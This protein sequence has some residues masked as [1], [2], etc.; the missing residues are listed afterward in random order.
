[1]ASTAQN[2]AEGPGQARG[3]NGQRNTPGSAGNGGATGPPAAGDA[4]GSRR[5]LG[6]IS[7]RG[8]SR[9][10]ALDAT[11]L[12]SQAGDGNGGGQLGGDSLP[13]GRDAGDP[14]GSGLGSLTGTPGGTSS[15]QRRATGDVGG[16]ADSQAVANP[17]QGTLRRSNLTGAI[18][19]GVIDGGA[20]TVADAGPGDGS[21]A[22]GGTGTGGTY[23]PGASNGR[24]PM[25]MSSAAGSGRRSGAD[26][27]RLPAGGEGTGG[28]GAGGVGGGGNA[29]GLGARLS[30]P[31]GVGTAGGRRPGGE[32]VAR[33]GSGRMPGRRVDQAPVID[34]RAREPAR[35][36]AGRGGQR[37]AHEGGADGASAR[38]EAAVEAGLHFLAG[39]Q[40]PAGSWSLN[41]F[42][43]SQ[44]G[45]ENERAAF[46]SDTAATGLALLAFL[47][48]GYDHYDDQYRGNIQRGLQFLLKNQQPNGDLYLAQDAMSN[49]SA[50]YYSHGIASIALCEAYGMTGDPALKVPAQRAIDFIIAS[51]NPTSGGW[52]Y[53]PRISADTS[54][55]G[56]QLMALKS[57]ELAGLSVPKSAYQLAA[58]WLDAAQVPPGDGSEYSYNPNAADTPQ[59]RH[60]RQPTTTMTAVG[61][62]MR[63]YLGWNRNDPNMQ[64]GAQ[65]LLDNLPGME[66]SVQRDTYYWYYATQVM[67]HMRG[68]YWLTWNQRLHPLLIDQ[69]LRSGP[70][71]GSWN[72]LGGTPDRWGEK[73]GRI[74]VTA[75][76]LLSL[77]VYYR[78]LPIYE[79]EAQ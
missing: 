30:G 41:S 12:A 64:A 2:L 35:A 72:P 4:P 45:F 57:G 25:A 65:H 59:S 6:K 46:R 68:Q 40:S 20:A 24:G 52:R 69:Q 21:A 26:L 55:S 50:R 39:L 3:P 49:K 16:A 31:G 61:L 7:G 36:F 71:T 77:E 22:V 14:S 10:T 28:T 15:G 42:A 32:L 23:A 18:P 37:K 67:F 38:T 54:V 78:H 58:K 48:A 44:P 51:Q 11:R 9:G 1:M 63:L 62:L 43:D 75:M 60:G 53:E 8:D 73:G 27:T 74:Y 33:V 34:T 79:S 13:G 19:G 47:G 70:G 17:R 5:G 29:E 66:N 56:W 76:N